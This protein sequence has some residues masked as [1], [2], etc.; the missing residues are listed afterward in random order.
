MKPFKI[1]V[2]VLA[3]TGF[4]LGAVPRQA[5]HFSLNPGD[6]ALFNDWVSKC[7]EDFKT[8]RITGR[9]TAPHKNALPGAEITATRMER[10]AIC[11][12]WKA[13]QWPNGNGS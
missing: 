12:Q 5:Q 11:R 4:V 2:C 7:L 1:I 10:D 3:I 9:I 6:R 13:P 8:A